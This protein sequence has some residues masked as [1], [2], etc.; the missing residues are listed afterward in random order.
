MNVIV[1]VIRK[2]NESVQAYGD[3]LYTLVKLR[4][5]DKP[6]Y[7]KMMVEKFVDGLNTR[8]KKD[9]LRRIHMLRAIDPSKEPHKLSEATTS[10]YCN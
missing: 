4:E 10:G 3:R 9:Y 6:E 2:P 5:F 1:N 7:E 8:A